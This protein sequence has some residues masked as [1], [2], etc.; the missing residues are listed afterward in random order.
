MSPVERKD[1]APSAVRSNP[2]G[3]A[4]SL[5]KSRAGGS[6][7]G[8]KN[9]RYFDS[10]DSGFG[11]LSALGAWAAAAGLG[12]ILTAC[13]TETAVEGDGPAKG[14]GP[15][16]G[17]TKSSSPPSSDLLSKVL[18]VHGSVPFSG[19]REVASQFGPEGIEVTSR[20]VERIDQDGTGRFCLEVVDVLDPNLSEPDEQLELILLN[21]SAGM[22]YRYRDFVI[23]NGDLFLQNY[24]VLDTGSRPDVAGFSCTELLVYRK[25]APKS[26]YSI[27][28]E[29]NSG[30]V[31]SLEQSA[32]DTGEMI[33]EMEYEWI[34]FA[35][36]HSNVL[37]HVPL[38]DETAIDLD[39]QAARSSL[40]FEPLVPSWV[41]D[42]YVLSECASVRD[43]SVAPDAV[44]GPFSAPIWQKLTYT[45][46]LETLFFLYGGRLSKPTAQ[47]GAATHQLFEGPENDEMMVI[48]QRGWTVLQGTVQR[49]RLLA[50]GRLDDYDLG[51]MIQSALP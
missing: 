48:E 42:S 24:E 1:L 23:H 51:V 4:G 21:Q 29:P 27:K 26:V 11:P 9:S 14:D 33:R 8:S 22:H 30:V 17:L 45:D 2:P 47:G 3:M 49:H 7:V 38:N 46:G 43:P 50:M 28:V 10:R 35:P 34:D 25:V 36:D 12:L 44:G 15:S 16:I 13:G 6:R 20:Y 41:P 18:G 31:L 19:E 5:A 39:S 32:L 37:W 40:G